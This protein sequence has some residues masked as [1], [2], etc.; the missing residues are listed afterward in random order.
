MW[1]C[2][3]IARSQRQCGSRCS[4]RIRCG[5]SAFDTFMGDDRLGVVA[6]D[7]N[8][9]FKGTEEACQGCA[10]RPAMPD[11]GQRPATTD[12]RMMQKTRAA[13]GKSAASSR[14]TIKDVAE[15]CGVHPSAVSRALSGAMS[16]LVAVS[17]THLRAHETR[18]DLVCR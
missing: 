15:R 3:G 11:P 18:H 5:V 14:P 7:C 13:T 6:I 10:G 1:P 17:Y 16:H 4:G 12:P 8:K 9:A 2:E